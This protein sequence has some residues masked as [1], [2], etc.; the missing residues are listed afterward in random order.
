MD[1]YGEP[2]INE[3]GQLS[4]VCDVFKRK[5]LVLIDGIADIGEESKIMTLDEMT[6]ELMFKGKGYY[7]DGSK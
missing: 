2:Y 5:T 1:R 7:I 4:I 3:S 6:E